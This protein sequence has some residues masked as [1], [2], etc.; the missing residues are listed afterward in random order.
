MKNRI[1]KYIS[2]PF[3]LIVFRDYRLFRNPRLWAEEGTIYFRDAY[4]FGFDKFFES[5]LGYYSLLPRL[6]SYLA[7]FFPIE[8]VPMVMTLLSLGIWLLPHVLV[9]ISKNEYLKS[10]TNKTLCSIVLI[11]TAPSDEIFLN[12]I[13]LHFLTPWI[14]IFISIDDLKHISKRLRWIYIGLVWIALL[15]GATSI[16]VLP[17]YMYFTV[18]QKEYRLLCVS[19]LPA[20]LQFYFILNYGNQESVYDR[21]SFDWKD[22]YP[23]FYYRTLIGPIFGSVDVPISIFNRFEIFQSSECQIGGCVAFVLWLLI[24]TIQKNRL[25]FA[26][27][28]SSLFVCILMYVSAMG[29]KFQNPMTGSGRYFYLPNTLYSIGFL[30]LY[31]KKTEYIK[32]PSFLYSIPLIFLFYS[33]GSEYFLNSP[34]C[35]DCVHWRSEIKHN[36]PKTKMIHIWPKGWV[37]DLNKNE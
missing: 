13:S 31:F 8:I 4:L 36:F 15:N 27:T 16:F 24:L 26:L 10:F 2:I 25:A 21:F 5:A 7:T 1:L 23:I 11:L 34:Y 30:F 14:L 9:A 35:S 28:A 37:I 33:S 3:L 12:S 19:L 20:L 29:G 17:I 32:F 18:S 6:F 22:F